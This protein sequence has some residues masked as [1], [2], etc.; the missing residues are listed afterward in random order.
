MIKHVQQIKSDTPLCH[1]QPLSN[2]EETLWMRQQSRTDGALSELRAWTLADAVRLPRLLWAL[3][4]VTRQHPY[5]DVRYRLDDDGSL[6][7]TFADEG[8]HLDLR[9]AKSDPEVTDQLLSLQHEPW[10]LERSTPIR[11]MIVHHPRQVVLGIALHHILAEQGTLPGLA[12]ALAALYTEGEAFNGNKTMEPAQGMPPVVDDADAPLPWLRR[13]SEWPLL[14]ADNFAAPRSR[15]TGLARKYGATVPARALGSSA[16]ESVPALMAARFARFV[17]ESGHHESL[18]VRLRAGVEARTM[19]V[20]AGDNDAS[21]LR[22]IQNTLDAKAP[23]SDGGGKE[24]AA[25]ITLRLNDGFGEPGELFQQ[26]L[27]LPTR[28]AHPDISLDITTAADG[29]LALMLT[30]GQAVSPHG[31]AFLLDRFL[32]SLKQGAVATAPLTVPAIEAVGK[33]QPADLAALILEEFR[34]TLDEPGMQAHDDFFDFGGHSLL[35]TRIIGRLLDAHGLEIDFNDFFS[36]P[37][38]AALA[39]RVSTGDRPA[40]ANSVPAETAD[41]PD[42]AP[43]ALAQNSL[44][45]AHVAHG[46]G[47]LFNLPFAV[48]LLDEVNEA[49]LEQAMADV[50]ERHAGLRTLFHEQDSEVRQRPVPVAELDRYR[51]FWN[52]DDSQE[53][54]LQSEAA[55]CF[56]L[57][58]E[59]PIRVRLLKDSHTGKRILSMLVHHM[60][61]DEWSL[62]TVMSDLSQA[63][64]ARDGGKAPVWKRAAPPFHQFALHQ[65]G[66][67]AAPEHLRYWKDHLGSPVA[68]PPLFNDS[69]SVG[70]DSG[71]LA[72]AWTERALEHPVS[73]RLY[74]VARH[75]DASLFSLIYTGIVLALHRLGGSRD[76]VIGTS[77]SGRTDPA[78]YETVGYFTTMVAHRTRLTPDQPVAG[79]LTGIQRRIGESMP[80]ADVP[81]DLI[82]QAL[83]L[84]PEHGLM[85]EAYIQI[86]ANNALNGS[87][88]NAAGETIRYRQIDP[89]KRESLFDLQFEIMEDRI[90]GENRLRLVITYRRERYQPERI[91]HL[92]DA[93]I[94]VL[95]FFADQEGLATL[96]A[97]VP[98]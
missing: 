96:V 69:P 40:A 89:D 34:R 82:Q 24:A 38:A 49:V 6:I 36:A 62:S 59:L 43:L 11:A 92:A 77:A 46:Q 90:D 71:S 52:S 74:Q 20:N 41:T 15:D 70:T 93:I 35:A 58:N 30:T 98:V 33:A 14:E 37:S 2:H 47:T 32:G 91:Q 48:E 23:M 16:T 76:I 95:G 51:W 39:E 22:A 85:F 1:E 21:V 66:Q 67:G 84:P 8:P 61:I 19:R 55:Y 44:W 27:P 63:Y 65:H 13:T 60:A 94:Q 83:G 12:K 9:Q 86:H 31:G 3:R 17:A 28:E 5:L 81:I 97:D 73:E 25:W 87:L 53:A 10:D 4:A 68:P 18:G 7:R 72:A 64:S 88:S 42:T 56:D 78:F 26:E 79:L 50:L 57:A 29:E 45:Q 75:H 80:Y 54:T